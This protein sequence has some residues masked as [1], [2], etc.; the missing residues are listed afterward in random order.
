MRSIATRR[1]VYEEKVLNGFDFGTLLCRAGDKPDQPLGVYLTVGAFFANTGETIFVRHGWVGTEPKS[2][3]PSRAPSLG[4]LKMENLRE[5]RYVLN[6]GETDLILSPRDNWLNPNDYMGAA[7][8]IVR[9]DNVLLSVSCSAW[10]EQCDLQ[11]ALTVLYS[12]TH[13]VKLHHVGFSHTSVA[14]MLSAAS[15]TEHVGSLRGL[16]LP[17]NDQARIFVKTGLMVGGEFQTFM[18]EHQHSN[19]I[20]ARIHWDLQM[21][22]PEDFLLWMSDALEDKA[23]MELWFESDTDPSGRVITLNRDGREHAIFAR[24]NNWNPFKVT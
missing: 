6:R 5:A 1:R 11:F 14:K 18:E 16:S 9:K 21:D 22:D 2:D 8:R 13:K 17:T 15:I 4:R 12:M 3:C 20:P 24:S 10:T 19:A 7:M 23:A